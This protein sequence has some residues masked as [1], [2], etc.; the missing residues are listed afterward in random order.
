MRSSLYWIS[1]DA[2]AGRL[3]VMARPRAGDWL[4]GEIAGW[5]GERIDTVVCLLEPH[6]I[7][8][9]GLLEEGALCS[10]E[11][12]EFLPFPIADR[13][14]PTSRSSIAA[15]VSRLSRDLANGR[16]VAVHCRAGI[17]RSALVAA[18]ILVHSGA[19]PER[20]LDLISRA[21]G[22]AVPDTEEQRAWILALGGAAR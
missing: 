14:I 19:R 15:L 7:S 20:A 6:E 3:G 10:S 4:P 18:S 1:C 13:G 2:V 16:A 17:G 11:G 5:K 21:R 9:L 22:C 8:E 12:I